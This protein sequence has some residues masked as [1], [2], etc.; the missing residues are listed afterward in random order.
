MTNLHKGDRFVSLTTGALIEVVE[1]DGSD[2]TAVA[3]VTASGVL[4]NTRRIL[5]TSLRTGYLTKMGRPAKT[6]YVLV[7]QLPGGH[8]FK[9]RTERN[10]MV[11]PTA[12]IDYTT[13]NDAEIAA[14]IHAA[15]VQA[16]AYT[17][18]VDEGKAELRKRISESGTRVHGDVAVNA[19]PNRRF[20]ATL[21]KENLT[22]RQYA[23]ICL[24]KPDATLAK[25]ILGE[26]STAYQST[27]KPGD[28]RLTVR[29]ATDEDREEAEL[30]ERRATLSTFETGDTFD[31]KAPF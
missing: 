25:K 11:D 20:D 26:D 4:T 13:M 29:F 16:K 8:P 1:A 9:P 28:W 14:H 10:T 21:A 19:A 15:D 17:N 23:E 3:T 6:G 18:L 2:R 31:D 27:L 7:S 30:N 12:D 24:T 22:K 5:T